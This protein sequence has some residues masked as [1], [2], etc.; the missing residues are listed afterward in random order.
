MGQE[1]IGYLLKGPYELPEEK[2]DAAI[3]HAMGVIRMLCA[4]YED[5]SADP[6]CTFSREVQEH[7]SRYAIDVE[8]ELEQFDM[9]EA[10]IQGEATEAVTDL[11]NIWNG[12]NARDCYTR[13]DP[14]D[15]EQ[16][17]FF[18]GDATWGDEPDGYAYQTIKECQRYGVLEFFG[19]R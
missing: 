19:I 2:K 16:V 18:C 11:Y 5:F 1:L 12:N 17:L 4:A 7:L 3:A 8:M 13:V 14:D 15:R 9:D 6:E 10:T